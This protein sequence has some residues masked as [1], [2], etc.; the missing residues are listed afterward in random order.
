M[1]YSIVWDKSF[2]S[3][4]YIAFVFALE[5]D[6]GNSRCV[7]IFGFQYQKNAERLISSGKYYDAYLLLFCMVEFLIRQKEARIS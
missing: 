2:L 5:P 7:I 3:I 6:R 4:W 1:H